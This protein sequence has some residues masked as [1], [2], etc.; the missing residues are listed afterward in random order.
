MRYVGA[1][2]FKAAR[3]YRFAY[4]PQNRRHDAKAVPLTFTT[5]RAVG[6]AAG[7]ASG[8]R[9][10][11]RCISVSKKLV[12]RYLL[13][14]PPS[15]LRRAQEVVNH[16]VRVNVESRD[17]PRW[18]VAY[19]DGAPAAASV[20]APGCLIPQRGCTSREPRERCC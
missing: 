1:L 18:V 9:A 5:F 6:L 12:V 2:I 15:G 13:K 16:T 10:A 20:C 4:E 19:G 11:A 3:P 7:C 17:R 14:K 8:T